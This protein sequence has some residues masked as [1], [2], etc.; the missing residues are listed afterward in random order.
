MLTTLFSLI[1]PAWPCPEVCSQCSWMAEMIQCLPWAST[2][3]PFQSPILKSTAHSVSIDAI[4]K[5][6]P[7]CSETNTHR[8]PTK[9]VLI[10]RLAE[11]SYCLYLIL[12]N[13]PPHLKRMPKVTR[14]GYGVS[15]RSDLH[16]KSNLAMWKLFAFEQ[17]AWLLCVTVLSL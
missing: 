11:E 14:T 1:P 7:I 10:S 8:P 2:Q 4:S 17:V 15:F 12:T 13:L 3:N 16:S 5:Q 9:S 6:L